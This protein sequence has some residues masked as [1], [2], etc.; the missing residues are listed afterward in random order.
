MSTKLS[1]SKK[2][3]A[4]T[5]ILLKAQKASDPA[6]YFGRSFDDLLED[7]DGA[8]VV[9]EFVKLYKADQLLQ[10]AVEQLNHWIPIENWLEAHSK[11]EKRNPAFE[12]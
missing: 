3:E 2:A 7:G 8:E 12:F 1:P 9:L 6:K 11:W 10:Q 4:M 5:G